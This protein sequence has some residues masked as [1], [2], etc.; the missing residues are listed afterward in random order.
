MTQETAAQKIKN[1]H[2]SCTENNKTEELKRK[3]MHEQFYQDNE[4]PSADKEISLAWLCSS[5]LK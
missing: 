1:Q 2:K 3:P 5:S 4:R